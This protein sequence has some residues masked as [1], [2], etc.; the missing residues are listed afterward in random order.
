[1]AT[2][3][4]H[5]QECACNCGG[6][7]FEV[8]GEPLLRVICHCSICQQFN[9]APFAD[10]VVYRSGAVVKPPREQ[11]TYGKLRPPPNVQRGKCVACGQPAIE[12]FETP[13]FPNLIMVPASM[14]RHAE[15]LPAPSAHMFYERRVADVHDTWP[16]YTGYW[17]SQLGFFRHLLRSWQR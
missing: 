12:L 7:R 9:E 14:H 5:T 16:K 1:M 11:I 8:I 3:N 10:V 13:V 15:T 17:R 6:V 2:E 4:E